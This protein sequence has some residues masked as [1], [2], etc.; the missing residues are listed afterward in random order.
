MTGL[1]RAIPDSFQQKNTSLSD[2][3]IVQ[4]QCSTCYTSPKNSDFSWGIMPAISINSH[5]PG[6]QF[7]CCFLTHL[8]L[9]SAS[10]CAEGIVMLQPLARVHL[11]LEAQEGDVWLFD[12]NQFVSVY[13]NRWLGTFWFFVC[14]FVFLTLKSIKNSTYHPQTKGS[15]KLLKSCSLS[16]LLFNGSFWTSPEKSWINQSFYINLSKSNKSTPF[17]W[18]KSAA[19][20][21]WPNSARQGNRMRKVEPASLDL[22]VFLETKAATETATNFGGDFKIWKVFSFYSDRICTYVS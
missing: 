4:Y 20:S 17:S 18:P 2:S 8:C 9:A 19:L 1:N 14:F 12:E 3:Q 10:A 11:G 7:A 16:K 22:C 5:L 15:P 6:V 13:S 21:W